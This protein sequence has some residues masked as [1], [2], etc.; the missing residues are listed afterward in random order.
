MIV[1]PLMTP[2]L[3]TVLSVV[4]G[5]GRNLLRSVA[6]VTAGAIAVV[7]VGFVIG[8]LIPVPVDPPRPPRW[9][10]GSTLG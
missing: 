8:E 9:L 10:A 6:L 4:S 2:I 3:G 5:D 7:A 1:A